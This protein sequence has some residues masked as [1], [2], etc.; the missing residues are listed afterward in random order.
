MARHSRDGGQVNFVF[1]V[2]SLNILLGFSAPPSAQCLILRHNPN[3]ALEADYY[4]WDAVQCN[5]SLPYICQRQVD[6]ASIGCI[7]S[8]GQGYQGTA[9]V[10]KSGKARANCK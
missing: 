8:D 10:S 2:F 3:S 6:F 4:L 7:L 5:A 9:Q 1:I